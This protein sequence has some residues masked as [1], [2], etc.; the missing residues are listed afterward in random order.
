MRALLKRLASNTDGATAVEYG[1]MLACIVLVLLVG[2]T[3]F[4]NEM[5]ALWNGNDASLSE[6]FNGG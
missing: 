5:Q 2:L 6:A 3:N 1:V 4:G